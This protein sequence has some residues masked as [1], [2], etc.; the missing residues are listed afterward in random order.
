[1]IADNL[2]T[3]LDKV[4]QTAPAQWVAC[5]PAHGSRGRKLAVAEGDDGR[6]LIKC[7]SR[8]CHPAQIVDAVGLT[9]SDLFPEHLRYKNQKPLPRGQR[10]LPRTI[11]TA[12]SLEIYVVLLMAES[13]LQGRKPTTTGRNR[14]RTA[15]IRLQNAIEEV[16][17]V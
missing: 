4:K 9:M 5:C 2:I 17:Y 7:W 12:L 15:V 11:L 6:L 13:L 1:M 14:L 10:F 16:E 8:G 3:R